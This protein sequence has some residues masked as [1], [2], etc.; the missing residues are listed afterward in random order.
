MSANVGSGGA[1]S[2]ATKRALTF[3]S[4]S[5]FARV[6]PSGRW[7][8]PMIASGAAAEIWLMNGPKS[9]VPVS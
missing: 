3:F 1:T 2:S 9:T 7:P 8:P 4:Y 6:V 5:C